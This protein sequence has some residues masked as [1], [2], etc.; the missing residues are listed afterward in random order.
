[1]FLNVNLK[2]ALL[3]T[4]IHIDLMLS[5]LLLAYTVKIMNTYES[6]KTQ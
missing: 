2:D 1:M 5:S 4:G 6:S 3:K